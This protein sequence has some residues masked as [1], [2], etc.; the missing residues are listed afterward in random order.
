[1]RIVKSTAGWT[2]ALAAAF[3]AVGPLQAQVYSTKIPSTVR[4]GSGHVDVP[5][6]SVLPHMAIVG[7]YSGFYANIDDELVIGPNGE[8]IGTR[9]PLKKWYSDGSLALGLG[10][11]VEVGAALHSLDDD[12]SGNL[13]GLFG[14]LALLRPAS[15]GAGIGLSVGARYANDPGYTDSKPNRLGFPD[16]N[17]RETYTGKD[18][19]STNLTGYAVASA[20]LKGFQT[21][22]IPDNDF[23]FSLGWGN[24]LFSSGN[25]LPFYSFA[26][27]KGLFVGA[28]M[29][30]QTSQRS[31]LNLSGDWNGFDINLGAQLDINGI[32]LGAHY[33]GSNYWGDTGIYR[34]PKF[35]AL[36][37]IAL[38]PKGGG[39][40]CRA[41]LIP[42]ALPDTV[43][44][45]APRPDTVIVT[46]DR[47]VAAPLPQGQASTIC[48]ATGENV[49]VLVTA[50]GDTLVGP[51]RTSIRVLRT[52]GVVFA[53]EYAQGRP[54]YEQNQ[55]ITFE[56]RS[57]QRSGGEIRLNCPDLKRIGEYMGVPLF[58]MANA[59]S[60]YAQIYVP[61]R[62][63]VWQMYENLRGTRG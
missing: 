47:E 30:M 43:R 4:W 31:V 18:E 60:P 5:S 50:Q 16:P 49:T 39:M 51:T 7:T 25:D 37:S 56:R 17:F 19:V 54:W 52:A 44:L 35:G 58:A 23:T 26:S 32:R 38:C 6:A 42:R 46:R 62:P 57:Y 10:N 20:F 14:Q 45:P 9:G 53:G 63:G 2:A 59:T 40:M 22:L 24:G 34:S 12:G 36:A 1:M 55:P 61:V 15:N 29:H 41:T 48:L 13:F 27:S 21:E 33:L 28:T 3:F 11:R 8:I